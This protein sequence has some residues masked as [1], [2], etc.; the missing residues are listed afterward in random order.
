MS[1]SAP[2]ST[3]V[4]L[5]TNRVWHAAFE[6]QGCWAKELLF[7]PA[8]Q[9][10]ALRF[11]MFP[12]GHLKASLALPP[13]SSGP[14]W[15]RFQPAPGET[16]PA[17]PPE[18]ELSCP[19]REGH[20]QCDVPTGVLD[21]RLKAQGLVPQYLW[22]V[23]V[24]PGKVRELGEVR[25]QAGASVS[26]FVEIRD[27][28][29]PP[30]AKVELSP[31]VAGAPTSRSGYERRTALSRQVTVNERGFFQFEAVPP[32]VY[33][34][35]AEQAGF[36]PVRQGPIEV[37]GDLESQILDPLRLERPVPMLVDLDPPIDPYGR[38]WRIKLSSID[39]KDPHHVVEAFSGVVA[40][41]GHLE[42]RGLAP[43]AYQLG[44]FDDDNSQWMSEDVEVAPGGAPVQVTLP[45]V[46]VRGRLTQGRNPLAATL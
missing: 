12:T 21:L 20:I 28:S 17:G 13:G 43:G 22:A 10:A 27:R 14:L 42:S 8:G 19:I 25:L 39:P 35:E 18:G 11:R 2:G 44:V 24:E 33:E 3:A 41:S 4:D 45:L 36:A 30:R 6:S 1:L 32:G 16:H 26:G 5:P 23:R 34:V 29:A 31:L 38:R 40:E 7:T 46:E 9:E 15:V 37:H